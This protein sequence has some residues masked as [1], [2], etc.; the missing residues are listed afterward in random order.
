MNG[1]SLQVNRRSVISFL[2]ALLILA[3]AATPALAWFEEGDVNGQR[4]R[5]CRVIT[6]SSGAHA[7]YCFEGAPSHPR[8][9]AEQP[10]VHPAVARAE[11]MNIFN[12]AP[13]EPI[14]ASALDQ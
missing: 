10:L 9:V 4:A 1:K 14:A 8:P 13:E 3:L 7:V 12:Q 6:D 5:P 2:L 11:Q